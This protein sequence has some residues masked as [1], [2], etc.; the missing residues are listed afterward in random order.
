MILASTS[1]AS[2]R[3]AY[4]PAQWSLTISAVSRSGKKHG[5]MFP[6]SGGKAFEID[7]DGETMNTFIRTS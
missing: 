1:Y 3:I 6:M 7:R 2:N 4:R 5:N